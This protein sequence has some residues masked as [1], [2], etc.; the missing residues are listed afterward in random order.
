MLN[1]AFSYIGIF[2]IYIISLLP[3]QV[4]YLFATM[5]YWALY[6][7]FGYRK[8][9]VRKNLTDAFPEKTV[10]E[11]I[12]IEKRFF[13]YLAAVIVEIVKMSTITKAELQK[14]Y[15]FKNTDRIKEYLNQGTSVLVC[16][17]HYGNWEWGTLAFG[18]NFEASSYP[19]YKPLS[20][21]V[22]D[23]WFYQI[24]TRFGNN[25]TPMK[26][27]YRALT[28]TR[29]LSTVFC[30][31]NDQAPPKNESHYWINFL[32]QPTA[33]QLGIEK[34]AKKTNRPVFYIKVSVVKKGYYEIDCI[35]LVM[36]PSKTN[37]HEITD[38]HVRFLENIIREEP[39]YWLWSHRRWKH[40][41]ENKT[42]PLPSNEV[43]L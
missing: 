20:N 42:T 34:I 36:D 22:F 41:P 35:P 13:K 15:V 27:T 25:M 1:K 17:A 37:G 7:V 40:Q 18:L 28:E 43:L 30:F 6:H 12:T 11:I 16:S 8:K 26:Q 21:K 23:N 31:G 2:F 29:E 38:L 4:L 24:R 3:M 10:Q 5:A 39:A 32:N 33:I 19:I 9:V 14:R